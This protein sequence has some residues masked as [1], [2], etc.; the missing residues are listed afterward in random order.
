MDHAC[1]RHDDAYANWG[2]A[3][4]LNWDDSWGRAETNFALS[5]EGLA[6]MKSQPIKGYAVFVT[7]IIFQMQAVPFL[8]ASAIYTVFESIIK[9][10]F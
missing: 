9:A 5:R 3:T 10:I 6:R 2:K 7:G 1:K 4:N 8:T